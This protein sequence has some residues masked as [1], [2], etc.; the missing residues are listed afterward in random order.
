MMKMGL[1]GSGK[2]RPS[3][4]PKNESLRHRQQQKKLFESIAKSMEMQ[5]SGNVGM[6]QQCRQELG[7]YAVELIDLP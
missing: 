5:I 6:R 3:S 1:A 7:L 4:F 2:H